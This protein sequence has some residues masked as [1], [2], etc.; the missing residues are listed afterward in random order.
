MSKQNDGRLNND[1]IEIDTYTT[2]WFKFDMQSARFVY[3][4]YNTDNGGEKSK[5]IFMNSIS[6]Y[7]PKI[8]MGKKNA[9]EHLLSIFRKLWLPFTE[10]LFIFGF[11]IG[12][13]PCRIKWSERLQ[14]FY[15]D[16]VSIWDGSIVCEHN[17]EIGSV[18]YH[19]VW[20]ER[21]QNFHVSEM[22]GSSGRK[23][24]YWVDKSVFFFKYSEPERI[25]DNL[26][27]CIINNDESLTYSLQTQWRSGWTKALSE[28]IY[29]KDMEYTQKKIEERK[30]K[31]NVYVTNNIPFRTEEFENFQKLWALD[32]DITDYRKNPEIR[33]F[34]S[35]SSKIR[36]TN[37][38][39][40]R[41]NEIVNSSN[42]DPSQNDSSTP[43]FADVPNGFRNML[44]SL[45]T[46]KQPRV[47][48]SGFDDI[49]TSGGF[50]APRSELSGVDKIHIAFDESNRQSRGVFSDPYHVNG[51]TANFIIGGGLHKFQHEPIP[52][53][54]N[55]FVE[56]KMLFKKIISDIY[57]MTFDDVIS[58]SRRYER[59][60]QTSRLRYNEIKK[61]IIGFATEIEN[62]FG[63]V[64]EIIYLDSFLGGFREKIFDEWVKHLKSV[65]KLKIKNN[66][67][68]DEKNKEKN[69]KKDVITDIEKKR[70]MNEIKKETTVEINFTT[71]FSVEMDDV[72]ILKELGVF[73]DEIIREVVV[74]QFDLPEMVNGDGLKF[75]DGKKKETDN[76]KRKNTSEDGNNKK[77]DGEKNK[78][79]KKEE[80][81]KIGDDEEKN[82]SDKKNKDSENKKNK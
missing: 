56:Q 38:S 19:W 15:P 61:N 64:Y 54:R 2:E 23:Q 39:L 76:K 28:Y 74:Q 31:P 5:K 14:E 8:K 16:A 59:T 65:S 30:I 29:F 43:S 27:S 53:G 37:E 20:Y 79:S 72:K 25:P 78:K 12:I 42:L 70:V 26:I 52:N 6:K 44:N 33:E 58:G 18:E 9:S 62:F 4:L 75:N 40:N 13:A 24:K 80:K 57:G 45:N 77:D 46:L 47:E 51:S 11:T 50:L 60:A 66:K 81:T 71:I 67:M 32:K 48:S 1:V 10:K 41:M 3:N 49:P 35:P 17:Y 22:S 63:D 7:D 73:D 36:K 68:I 69:E 55:D 34:L 82:K 21:N